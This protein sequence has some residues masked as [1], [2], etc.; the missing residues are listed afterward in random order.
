M[1]PETP[2]QSPL[3]LKFI[4]SGVSVSVLQLQL[5]RRAP[6]R[7]AFAPASH[8]AGVPTPPFAAL[9]CRLSVIPVALFNNHSE[10]KGEQAL[11]P[12]ASRPRVHPVTS[13]WERA[14]ETHPSQEPNATWPSHQQL[15]HKST[16]SVLSISRA[17]QAGRTPLLCQMPR[18]RTG[19]GAGRAYGARSEHTATESQNGRGWQG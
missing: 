13:P 16:V 12:P 18:L 4:P 1:G 8:P 9:T 19:G 7:S 2:L 15:G 10:V 11:C 17:S 14:S 6:W 5:R 3:L